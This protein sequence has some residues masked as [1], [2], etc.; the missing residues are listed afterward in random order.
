MMK[1]DEYRE[2]LAKYTENS[3]FFQASEIYVKEFSIISEL[4][5]DTAIPILEKLYCP[6]KYSEP[7]DPV[8][9]L[10][11]LL[12]MTLFG[13]KGITGWVEKTRAFPV[14]AVFCGADPADTPGTGT[15]YDFMNRITDGPYRKPSG[16]C[17]RRSAYNR[18]R[19]RGNPK[20]KKTD[21]TIR[22]RIIRSRKSSRRN[23][24]PVTA[25]RFPTVLKKPSETFFLSPESFRIL[26][27]G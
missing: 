22:L 27:P 14:I 6:V 2:H 20:E 3:N 21:R 13:E 16:G 24:S 12:L 26:N 15:Y 5:L 23:C 10:R 9:M 18:V 7:R 11:S 8:C 17:V 25:D 4:N 19:H 1:H